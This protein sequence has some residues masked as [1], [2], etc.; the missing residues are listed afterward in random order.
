MIRGSVF[1]AKRMEIVEQVEEEF[2]Y[3]ELQVASMP[4][5]YAGKI[6]AALDRQHPRDKFDIK[7]LF[8]NEGFTDNLRKTFLVFLISYQR[9]MSELLN[10]NRKNIREI[11]KNE[12]AQM[13]EIEITVEELEDTR[14]QLIDIINTQLTKDERNFLISFKSKKP[15]WELLGL[16]N[17]IE[18]ANLPSVKWKLQN[19]QKMNDAKHKAALEKLRAVLF[20]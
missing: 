16:P 10:P 5:L 8:E 19:L 13:T 17:I 18:V 15:N 6:C 20:D 1:P 3:A 14:E 2:G 12:F 4:D 7:L 9:P 11:Y